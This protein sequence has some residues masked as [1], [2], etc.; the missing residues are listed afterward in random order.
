MNFSMKIHLL[1]TYS[2][3]KIKLDGIEYDRLSNE[4]STDNIIRRTLSENDVFKNLNY[5]VSI[6]KDSKYI[7]KY[8]LIEDLTKYN[9]YKKME[10]H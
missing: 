2:N 6:D 1:F 10:I 8:N 4:F 5:M 7:G 3:E 9:L